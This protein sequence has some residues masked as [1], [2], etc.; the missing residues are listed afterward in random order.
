MP[1]VEYFDYKKWSH[2]T[3]NHCGY[4]ISLVST[5]IPSVK[6]IWDKDLAQI[7][8]SGSVWDWAKSET[9][10]E[11]RPS[12]I[13]FS[14]HHAILSP[15][16]RLK[17]LTFVWFPNVLAIFN[18]RILCFKNSSKTIHTFISLLFKNVIREFLLFHLII[19]FSPAVT[20]QQ[21][22]KRLSALSLSYDVLLS[23]HWE[24]NPDLSV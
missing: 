18:M 16:F 11:I 21:E 14:L 4:L 24:S 23:H 22:K 8:A 5:E 6:T 2:D 17:D 9:F 10:H 13:R 12:E 15:Y 1:S 20:L 19:P 3:G 7:W